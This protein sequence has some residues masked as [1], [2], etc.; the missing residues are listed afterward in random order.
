[1]VCPGVSARPS[2]LSAPRAGLT[3]PL[4]RPPSA[5]SR[6][7]R[8]RPCRAAIRPRRVTERKPPVAR[9]RPPT[10]GV[11]Q[12]A[13]SGLRHQPRPTATRA[14]L[15]RRRQSRP[16]AATPPPSA[17]TRELATHPTLEFRIAISP[18][19][20]P[21]HFR[22]T[23]APVP[24]RLALQ[25]ENHTDTQHVGCC[26]ISTNRP[27]DGGPRDHKPVCDVALLTSPHPNRRRGQNDDSRSCAKNRR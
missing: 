18:K 3:A 6:S 22:T 13:Q 12:L 9:P 19:I 8:R 7:T 27:A 16:G 1:M 17:T 2:R 14:A 11:A 10:D 20:T 21:C 15:A 25:R 23:I 4:R 5:A 24:H 26:F